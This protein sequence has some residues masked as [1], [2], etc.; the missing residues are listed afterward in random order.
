MEVLSNNLN[1]ISACRLKTW[2]IVVL[3]L[4][5]AGYFTAFFYMSHRMILLIFA[6]AALT[7]LFLVRPTPGFWLP[8]LPLVFVVG[9]ATLPMGEFNPAIATIAVF[10]FTLFYVADRILWNKPLFVPS[11]YLAFFLIAVFIQVCSIFISIHFHNQYAWNAIRDGSSLFLFFPLAVIIPSLCNTEKKINRLLRALLITILLAALVGVMQYFSFT[12]FSRVDMSLGYIYRGRVAS[13][14]GNPNVFAGYLELSIPLAL[15]LFFIEKDIKWKATAMTV[16][17]LGV[18]SVLYT[19]SRG[20]LISTFIGCGIT[21]LYVF[22]KKV[23]VPVLL[24]ITTIF[25]L[26]QFAAT[27]ERQMSFIMNPQ[28]QMTQPTLLHRYISYRGFL[29]QFS[30]SPGTGVG[31]GARSFYWGRSR[32]YSF[33]EVRF[34]VSTES[35]PRF[36]GLNSLFLNHAVKGGIV[37]LVS[38]LLVF[39]VIFVAFF[40]ALR[41]GKGVLAVALFAGLFSFMVHQVVGNQ[42]RFPTVNSQFWIVSGLLLTIAAP[43]SRVSKAKKNRNL[44]GEFDH[45]IN[46]MDK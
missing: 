46:E 11:L 45:G 16:V 24:G 8:V 34:G 17:I 35:I 42:L 9:G 28:D 36:G 20:G 13:F 1:D 7:T 33:W 22:R 32:L 12:S 21:L 19:F 14:F 3:L 2:G 29:N 40:K 25:V 43:G 15:A 18:L 30:E 44:P 10:A 26:I 38:V 31:Y 6:G 5:T 41:I 4:L 23:W 37:S 39:A 27:F